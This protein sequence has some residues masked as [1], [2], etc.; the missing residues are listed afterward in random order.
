[1]YPE[2][3]IME[4][5][6]SCQSQPESSVGPAGHTGFPGGGLVQHPTCAHS[7]GPRNSSAPSL[8]LWPPRLTPKTQN[9]S[10]P[11]PFR[12]S[13]GLSKRRPFPSQGTTR[14]EWGCGSSPLWPGCPCLLPALPCLTSFLP[15]P[16]FSLT[17]EV[18]VLQQL[19][20]SFEF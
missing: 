6:S 13:G 20:H 12:V 5:F 8:S 9:H 15:H 17:A 14:S 19:L 16:L 2:R 3:R 10:P 11:F 7:E 18:I 1:M 4:L